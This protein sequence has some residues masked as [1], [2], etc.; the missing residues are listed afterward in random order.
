[1]LFR[2]VRLA[3]RPQAQGQGIGVRLLAEVVAF[4]RQQNADLLTLNTQAYNHRAQ[5][6]YEKFGFLLTDESQPVLRYDL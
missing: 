6:L 3:V 4:A 1:M 5:M 2:S